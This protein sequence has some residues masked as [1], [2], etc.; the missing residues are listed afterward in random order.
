MVKAQDKQRSLI[1]KTYP[2]LVNFPF[3]G[4]FDM[5]IE[6]S[7]IMAI[8]FDEAFEAGPKRPDQQIIKFIHKSGP[9]HTTV[10]MYSQD[11]LWIDQIAGS[12]KQLDRI[13][14]RINRGLKSKDIILKI[15]VALE[16]DQWLSQLSDNRH[17][18]SKETF[19]EVL[20]GLLAN[21]S[22]VES[23]NLIN[24]IN[25]LC[26]KKGIVKLSKSDASVILTYLHFKL[27]Y[28]KLMLGL[29][30]ASKISL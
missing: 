2:F 27:I 7:R 21:R 26:A 5:E 11:I 24:S 22:L 30:I 8:M 17:S 6:A 16:A 12:V 13:S 25:K 10:S 1:N 20:Q 9:V 19:N 4:D 14:K 18:L 3:D 23:V 29:V 28:T 15:D